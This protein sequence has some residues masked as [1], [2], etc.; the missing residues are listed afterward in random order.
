M[1]RALIGGVL[2]GLMG[3]MLGSFTI[4]RQL[5]FFS[6]ALGHS[7]LLGIS[8][9]LLLGLNPS[10][11]VLPFAVL[12]ALGVN[13]LLEHTRLW[14]D[15]LLNI[16]YSS[17]LA[18]AIITLSFV[19]RYKGGLHNLLFGDILAVQELDLVFS[20]G[21]LIVCTVFIGLT[22]RTQ[23]LMTLN[24]P[25]AIARGVAVSAHRTAFIVL[26]SLVVGI[27]IKAIGVLLVS[28]FIVI[29]ACAA[30]FL[31]RTFAHYVVLSAGL[32]ALS[33]VLGMV[34]S[35]GFNLPSGPSIVATQLAIFLTAIALPN[36]RLPVHE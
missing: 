13:Y 28:A 18:I 36:L 17:S 1:Q 26:L 21:L 34:I 8:I 32:G 19:G 35:A 14:T 12:F 3:G 6:D 5:S 2:T 30:R 24:E 9:G 16:I 25:L 4:L 20:G 7:A 23:M 31:S 27:S 11:V 15:A 29:P 22:L 33:A 10:V